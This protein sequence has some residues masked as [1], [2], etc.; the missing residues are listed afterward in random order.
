MLKPL[1]PKARKQ[2]MTV[3]CKGCLTISKLH[4]LGNKCVSSPTSTAW[5]QDITAT[6]GRR[7]NCV[8]ILPAFFCSWGDLMYPSL[9]QTYTKHTAADISNLTIHQYLRS[10]PWRLHKKVL[11]QPNT[12]GTKERAPSLPPGDS[13]VPILVRQRPK[14]CTYLASLDTM[15]HM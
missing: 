15:Q 9:G 5:L 8:R 12:R 14:T 6:T 13:C 3:A 2:K 4:S 1:E 10:R 11:R 7:S